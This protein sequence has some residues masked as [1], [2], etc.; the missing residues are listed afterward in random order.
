[1]SAAPPCFGNASAIFG[2]CTIFHTPHFFPEICYF[3]PC[4]R[5]EILF[6]Y[7]LRSEVL[8]F[9]QTYPIVEMFLLFMNYWGFQDVEPLEDDKTHLYH[10]FFEINILLFWLPNWMQDTAFSGAIQGGK[11]VAC[12][13]TGC[14][15]GALLGPGLTRRW[16]LRQ[17]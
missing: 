2:P 13:S 5:I 17:A 4:P 1:M 14:F 7:V 12:L 3:S 15:T 8:Y 11:S 6:L 16:S 9:C 10:I